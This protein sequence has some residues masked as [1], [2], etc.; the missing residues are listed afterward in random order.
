[1][2]RPFLRVSTQPVVVVV[3]ALIYVASFAVA[4]FACPA[5]LSYPTGTFPAGSCVSYKPILPDGSLA[6]CNGVVDYPFYLPD[7]L[8]QTDLEIAAYNGLTQ[9]NPLMA[10]FL[11]LLPATCAIQIKRVACLAA[12]QACELIDPYYV[13]QSACP[14]GQA[15]MTCGDIAAQFPPQLFTPTNL[16][17]SYG[18]ICV[19][20]SGPVGNASACMVGP[21]K[22]PGMGGNGKRN[23]EWR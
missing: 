4:N 3:V 14:L 6:L 19:G 18:S 11:S 8:N 1:M 23:D 7:G 17:P 10:T 16:S 2:N 5:A 13:D 15:C 20:Q 21:G 12:F 9:G 22:V